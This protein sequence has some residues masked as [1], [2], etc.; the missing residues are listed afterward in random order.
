MKILPSNKFLF[1]VISTILI[2]DSSAIFAKD[3]KLPPLPRPLEVYVEQ[4]AQIRYLGRENR[5]DGWMTI[6]NGVEEYYYVP[7]NDRSIFFMGMMFDDNGKVITFEQIKRLQKQSDSLLNTLVGESPVK[8]DAEEE[9]AKKPESPA[10]QLYRD[11]EYSN[12]VMLGDANAPYIYVFI[13]PQCPHCHDFMKDL[14]DKYIKSGKLQVR[15]IPVGV[16]KEE[17]KKQAAFIMAAPNGGD[18]WLEYIEGNKNAISSDERLNTQGVERNHA[19]MSRWKFN[20]TPLTI[21]KSKTGEIKLLRGR[22][23]N[24]DDIINDL[25]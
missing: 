14:K 25:M 21:Y 2:V 3:E 10:Q 15:I 16:L 18:L 6:K 7:V 24:I 4:G 12:W 9:K 13:D 1:M 11:V 17:S 8:K 19:L 22:A 20:E 23:K 5:Y